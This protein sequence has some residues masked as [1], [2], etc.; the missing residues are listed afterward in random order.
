MELNR[1]W[2]V[3]SLLSFS[4]I[5]QH[6]IKPMFIGDFP[7]IPILCQVNPVHTTATYPLKPHF[8]NIHPVVSLLDFPPKYILL[9]YMLDALPITLLATNK[10]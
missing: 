8:N 7:L 3:G 10:S 5:S 4:R 6:F 2:E 1:S 9:P